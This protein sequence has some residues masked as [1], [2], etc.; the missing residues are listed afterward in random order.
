[1]DNV[2]IL[3]MKNGDV[4]LHSHAKEGVSVDEVCEIAECEVN[5]GFADYARVTVNGETY[6]EYEA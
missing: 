4:V 5:G 2:W 1:M 6:M 3:T